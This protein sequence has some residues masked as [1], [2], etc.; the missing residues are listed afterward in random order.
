MVSE[1]RGGLPVAVVTGGSRGIGRLVADALE[2]TGYAV[3]RGSSSVAP[4]TDRAALQAWVADIVDRHGRIDVLVNSAGVIDA[5]VDLFASDPD[6]WWQTLEVNVLGVYLTTWLVAP[7]M[8]A[9]GGGRIINLNSGAG[10]RA[11]T[12]STAYNV[13]KTAVARLT[14]STELAGAA[15]GIRAFDL[16]PG[17]V[18]TDMTRGMRVHDG[19]TEWTAP[20]DVVDL[21]LALADGR[22]D[23]WS[24]RFLRAGIDTVASLTARTAQEP[25]AP[26]DRTLAL[27]PYGVEDPLN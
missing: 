20:Q 5:E 16:M 1:E 19:R 9:G 14:G 18:D 7:H 26:G 2:E 27:R 25:L 3:E 24:G 23:A 11:G 4:V 12:I 21:V 13:S 6:D 15:H 22:L 17:V 8:R 10:T